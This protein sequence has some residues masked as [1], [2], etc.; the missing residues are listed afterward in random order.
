MRINVFTNGDNIYNAETL[1]EVSKNL[2]I[3]QFNLSSVSL[4]DTDFIIWK[5]DNVRDIVIHYNRIKHADLHKPIILRSD[6]IVMDG[7]HRIIKGIADGEKSLPARRLTD[8][9]LNKIKKD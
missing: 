8:D 9:L 3:E 5:L 7:Y 1:I 4:D 2:P 6:G